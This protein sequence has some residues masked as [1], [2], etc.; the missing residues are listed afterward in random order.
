MGD[1]DPLIELSTNDIFK[2]YSNNAGTGTY[3]R[4]PDARFHDTEI[5]NRGVY[6]GG[7]QTYVLNFA[8]LTPGDVV[9]V[10]AVGVREAGGSNRRGN[11]S[12]NT[13]ETLELNAANTASSNQVTFAP[14]QVPADGRLDLSLSVVPG[15]TYAYLHGVLLEFS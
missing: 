1:F 14:T 11:L 5:V 15:A 10:S 13:G 2:N 3:A 4:I 12:L 7:T 6:I 8:G 9:T